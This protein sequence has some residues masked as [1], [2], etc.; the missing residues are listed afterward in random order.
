MQWARFFGFVS[1]QKVTQLN[2]LSCEI[3][4]SLEQLHAVMMGV[5]FMECLKI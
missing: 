5:Q 3:F 1:M 2:V 4:G